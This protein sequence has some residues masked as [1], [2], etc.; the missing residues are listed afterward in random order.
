M[1]LRNAAKRFYDFN[2]KMWKEYPIHYLSVTSLVPA[3][4]VFWFDYDSRY[5]EAEKMAWLP[6]CIVL[7]VSITK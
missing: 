3:A 2:F 6:V 1:S 7:R 4:L 5:N